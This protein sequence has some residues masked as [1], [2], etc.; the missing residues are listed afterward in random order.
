MKKST[1]F[2]VQRLQGRREPFRQDGATIV[3]F[4]ILCPFALLLVLGIIQLGLLFTAKEVVNE[5][6]F[7]AARAG[8]ATHAERNTRTPGNVMRTVATKALIPFYQDTT[9]PGEIARLL[10][11]SGKAQ[12]DTLI[13]IPL[14]KCDLDIQVLNPTPAAFDDFGLVNNMSEN[15]TYIPNDNLEYRSRV[16]G[17]NSK[18]SI[19]DANVLKIKVTYGYQ[20]K[21]PLMESVIKSV[22]CGFDTGIDAFGRGDLP[23]TGASDCVSYYNRGR[24]PIVVYATVQM[25]TPAWQ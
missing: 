3:E 15:H 4:T 22:M 13:C 25:Q 12:S 20:I 17:N 21:V 9:K 1:R 6:A 23:S 18:L 10:D 7:L 19:Q 16:P 14:V 2:T 11:A 8:A 24:I 5:A